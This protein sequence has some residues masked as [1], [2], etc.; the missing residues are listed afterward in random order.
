[1]SLRAGL[2]LTV[3]IVIGCATDPPAEPL[4]AE[5]SEAVTAAVSDTAEQLSQVTTSN[6]GVVAGIYRLIPCVSVDTD[7][8]TFVTVTYDCKFPFK[9]QGVVHFEKADPET[10][11]TVTD[12]QINS[13]AIDSVTTLVVPA[14]PTAT[15]TFFGA[16]VVDGPRR[17]LD[18]AVVATWVVDGR[19]IVL[20]ASGA[21]SINGVE[22]PWAVT[23]KRVCHRF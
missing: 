8:S 16:L 17:E 23:G 11:N 5:E 15:R 18:S 21:V 14:D 2:F 13:V 20:D 19:C 10:L 7:R 22:H 6:L 9:I 3:F 12:L 4:T 1:M